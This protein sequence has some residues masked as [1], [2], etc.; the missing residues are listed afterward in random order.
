MWFK[1]HYCPHS[2]SV[3]NDKGLKGRKAHGC[4]ENRR[5]TA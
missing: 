5:D 1:D 2:I 3:L 4:Q